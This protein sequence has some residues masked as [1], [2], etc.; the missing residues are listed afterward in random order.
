M[1]FKTLATGL[2]AVVLT[3]VLVP[4]AV[5]TPAV[6]QSQTSWYV[7]DDPSLFGPSQYWYRCDPGHGYGSNNCRFTYAIGGESTAG[8]W[9]R[10]N[11][12]S[13]DGRQEIQVY[14]PSNHATATVN[15]NI[16]IGRST[17]KVRVAQNGTRGWHSLGNWNTNGANV[18]IAVYDNDA[19]HHWDRD[20]YASSSIG[21]D[22]IRMRCVSNCGPP[23]PTPPP[24]PQSS[25][26]EINDL[27]SRTGGPWYR[28]SAGA[29]Y[30]SNNFRYTYVRGAT[31]ASGTLITRS[32]RASWTFTG[33]P[34][35]N[36]EVSVYVPSARATGDAT[37][38]FYENESGNYTKFARL[39]QGDHSGW[40]RL[41]TLDAEGGEIRIHLRNYPSENKRVTIDSRGYQYNRIAADAMR[42]TCSVTVNGGVRQVGN[43]VDGTLSDFY[44]GLYDTF[45]EM[46]PSRNECDD[47]R[48]GTVAPWITTTRTATRNGPD[49][50]VGDRINYLFPLG[51]CT[52]WVQFRVRATSV[53]DFDNGYLHEAF[54]GRGG[55]W[56]H[57]NNW[58]LKAD[59]AGVTRVGG[60]TTGYTP[61][62]HSV[63]QWNNAPLG[64]VAFVEAVSEDGGTIWVSEMNNGD[65]QVCYLNVRA[66]RK[67]SRGS[68]VN[69]WPEN[70]I[71]F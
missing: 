39:D 2:A 55:P 53:S 44:S 68:G 3:T 43:N 41:T 45:V 6:A 34:E 7:N 36:C 11:M 17:S 26:D 12:G 27:P 49:Y 9:A 65:R 23:P 29:G 33:V 59:R 31:N 61:R 47:R 58:D 13:R 5:T 30:G 66:I 62:K 60:T 20:G 8:N 63:A 38:H 52:S 70:F 64:H 56:S 35:G 50:D 10:W 18:V 46:S 42:L 32:N 51:E 48:R 15:Y 14:V 25:Y 16:T 37:Y 22:A 57:A 28:G 21:V 69:R 71:V 54:G 19:S 4:I 67:N 1:R 24:S 40:T